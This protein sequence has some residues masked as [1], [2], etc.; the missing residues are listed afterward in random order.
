MKPYQFFLLCLVIA[1]T[2]GYCVLM[3]WSWAIRLLEYGR[4][5]PRLAL[6]LAAL[7]IFAVRYQAGPEWA[8]VR[9]ISHGCS[10]T[11]IHTEQGK[12]YALG[13]G[14]A[15]DPE[16]GQDMSRRR[17][18]I[19]FA[20]P[21]G[22]PVGQK[23]PLECR[24]LALD[25]NLD[26]SLIAI[27]FG[28]LPYVCPVEPYIP[29]SRII[30]IG[31]DEMKMPI[32]TRWATVLGSNVG[33]FGGRTSD[34]NILFTR[35]PPWHGRSGGA[36]MDYDRWRLVGVCSA[37]AGSPRAAR[38]ES[39]AG[40]PGIYVSSTAIWGFL[41]RAGWRQPGY[42]AQTQLYAPQIQM[43]QQQPLPPCGH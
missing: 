3:A 39:P 37:Y 2:V 29:G 19:D 32:T 13:C 40:G 5:L 33:I 20:V 15:Y 31:Y 26:L 27:P 24:V 38:V 17:S 36:L 8:V 6:V 41:Q 35:E 1:A 34:Q 14:H 10:A 9:L 4:A 7:G 25:R 28:P 30:S 22:W 11:I 16:H 42:A 12:S 21:P 23:T 18:K 43:Q